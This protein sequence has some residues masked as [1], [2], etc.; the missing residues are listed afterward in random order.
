MR[1]HFD[2]ELWGL[3]VHPTR[4]EFITVG[5][6]NLLAFWDSAHRREKYTIT[7]EYPAKV[8]QISPNGRLVAIGCTNG[9]TLV[10][11]YV[12]TEQIQSIKGRNLEITEIKFSPKSRLLAVGG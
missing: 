10:Y 3:S 9:Y 12:N 11:D 7:L 8:V 5:E 4:K 2:G 1:G 6:D